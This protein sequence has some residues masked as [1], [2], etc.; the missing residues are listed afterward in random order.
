MS[1]AIDTI[2]ASAMTTVHPD[3][4][5]AIVA[6]GVFILPFYYGLADIRHINSGFSNFLGGQQRAK[7]RHF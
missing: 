3:F 4:R 5:R 2:P 6:R 1:T 7:T